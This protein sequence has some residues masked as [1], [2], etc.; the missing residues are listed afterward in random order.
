MDTNQADLSL[1]IREVRM[2]AASFAPGRANVGYIQAVAIEVY[3]LRPSRARLA[4]AMSRLRLES[5][6]LPS[7]ATVTRAI[8]QAAGADV[9]EVEGAE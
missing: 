8:R 7:M 4:V 6:G 2:L 3:R 5:D 9:A 1:I